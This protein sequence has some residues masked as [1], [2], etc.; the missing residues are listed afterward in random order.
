MRQS[1]TARAIR[2]CWQ[3]IQEGTPPNVEE[4]AAYL[5]M[6]SR[7]LNRQFQRELGKSARDYILNL[8]MER[9]A[10]SLRANPDWTVDRVSQDAGFSNQSAFT[11]AFRAWSGFSPRDYRKKSV[12]A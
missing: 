10:Q 2:W 8:R 5:H 3:Q 6:S 11:A 9:A 12:S 1:P 7:T 4:L